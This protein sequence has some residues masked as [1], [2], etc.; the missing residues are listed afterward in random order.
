[1]T[2]ATMEA[3]IIGAFVLSL[4][5]VIL[6]CLVIDGIVKLVRFRKATGRPQRPSRQE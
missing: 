4:S 1:M 2:Q 6:L 5:A 3:L